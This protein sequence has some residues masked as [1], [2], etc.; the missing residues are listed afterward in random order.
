MLGALGEAEAGIEHDVGWVDSGRDGPIHLLQEFAS[1]VLDDVVVVRYRT[2]VGVLRSGTPVHQNPWH[3]GFGDHPRHVRIGSSTG[4]VVDYGHARLDGC[5]CNRRSH[6]VDAGCHTCSAQRGDDRNY[7]PGLD[8]GVDA[9]GSWTRGFT[10]DIDD[11][12]SHAVQLDAV[13]DRCLDVQVPPAVGKRI[14]RDVEHAHD[15]RGSGQSHASGL[16]ICEESDPTPRIE[17]PHSIGAGHEPPTSWC[18]LRACGSRAS[19]C[20]DAPLR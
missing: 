6:R 20:I 19:P 5:C 16:V 8:S 13:P 11:V 14:G 9:V 7:P 12:D 17:T 3:A 18:S 4:Y 2:G 15:H 1:N 10:S